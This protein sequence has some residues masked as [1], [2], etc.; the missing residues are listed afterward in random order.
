MCR[1]CVV[2]DVVVVV[3]DLASLFGNS[4]NVVFCKSTLYPNDKDK[5]ALTMTT[6]QQTM[7]CTSDK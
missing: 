6:K 4:A 2:V 7:I 3:V 1:C 5:R